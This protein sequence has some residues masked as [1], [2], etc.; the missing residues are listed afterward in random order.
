V[1][2]G[3]TPGPATALLRLTLRGLR[4]LPGF[5]QVEWRLRLRLLRRNLQ[6]LNDAIA[7]TPFADH[8]WLFGGVLL[9]WAREGALL[10]HDYKDADFAYDA[11]DDELFAAAVPHIMRAGF[12][13]R[14]RFRSNDGHYSEHTFQ[15]RGAKFEFFRL[16]RH[17]DT[18]RYHTYGG[19]PYGPD[20]EMIS[21]VPAQRLES[22]EF[23]DRRWMKPVDHDLDL[24]TIYGEWRV[25]DPTWLFY[26]DS[27]IVDRRPRK[28]QEERWDGA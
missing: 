9:G 26:D 16:T 3:S 15:R 4:K 6:R 22:I 12:R 27:S 24:T 5:H 8:Y 2:G 28:Y 19:P 10:R 13:P 11:A 1:K 25:P 7:R 17:G 20:I 21:E 14:N 23:L 18:F